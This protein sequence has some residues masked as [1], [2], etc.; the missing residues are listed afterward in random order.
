MS[1]PATEHGRF[2]DFE[3]VAETPQIYEA[4][5]IALRLRGEGLQAE[6]VD[7]VFHQEPLPSVRALSVVRVLVPVEQ[8]ERA[9]AVLAQGA[10]EPLPEDAELAAET[11]DANQAGDT[12]PAASEPGTRA[13]A[14]T[15]D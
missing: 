14:G 9:R 12:A 3:Q 6:L 10:T 2:G 1:E 7:Q 8:A 13:D 5:F 15:A 11:A 4:E